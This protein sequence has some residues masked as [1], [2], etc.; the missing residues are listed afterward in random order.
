MSFTFSMAR[1][2]LL[3]AVITNHNHKQLNMLSVLCGR[4][5]W[6]DSIVHLITKDKELNEDAI[7]FSLP[8]LIIVHPT[9]VNLC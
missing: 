1:E 3:K 9:G 7:Y 8:Q 2:D 5:V 6:S 4:R